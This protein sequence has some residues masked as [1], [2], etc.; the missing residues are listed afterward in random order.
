MYNL[1]QLHSSLSPCVCV[2]SLDKEFSLEH[3]RKKCH[4]T[5]Q[6]DSEQAGSGL[7]SLALERCRRIICFVA[8]SSG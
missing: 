6:A 8:A 1:I 7:D 3:R 5:E 2:L 4:M